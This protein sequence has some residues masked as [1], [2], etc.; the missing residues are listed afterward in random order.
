MTDTTDNQHDGEVT[1]NG[2]ELHALQLK[3]TTLVSISQRGFLMNW[4]L[5]T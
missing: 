1:S 2:Q 5:N 3:R 4:T